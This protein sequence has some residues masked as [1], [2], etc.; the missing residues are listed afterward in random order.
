MFGGAYD[1]ARPERAPEV[2]RPEPAHITATARVSASAPV[3]CVCALQT[4]QRA[5][6]VFGDST[7]EPT[8]IATIDAF[9]PIADAVRGFRAAGT[10][11]R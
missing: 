8:A 4:L 10:E 2:R 6:F 5:T 9:G 11:R 1:A 3:T 7:A